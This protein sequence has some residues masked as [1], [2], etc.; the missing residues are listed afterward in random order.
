MS[1]TIEQDAGIPNQENVDAALSPVTQEEMDA[2]LKRM[3]EAV[4]ESVERSVQKNSE[5]EAR[6]ENLRK[7]L[8]D[9]MQAGAET[10]PEEPPR[11]NDDGGDGENKKYRRVHE[12][13]THYEY[14]TCPNCG[15]S[16][17]KFLIFPCSICGGS[18][19]VLASESVSSSSKDIKISGADQNNEK[20]Q[21]PAESPESFENPENK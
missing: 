4:T 1:K 19:R 11:G 14:E 16:G 6:L 12:A 20:T 15:G 13:Q 10:P 5:D 8:N 21:P 2:E 9:D 17:R 3:Q 7:S 18:G